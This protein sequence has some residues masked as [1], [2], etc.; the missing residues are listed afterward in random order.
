[1]LNVTDK[2]ADNLQDKFSSLLFA[3]AVFS[4]GALLMVASMSHATVTLREHGSSDLMKL[5]LT[6]SISR[7]DLKS[8]DSALQELSRSGKRLHMNAIEI[9]S[10]GGGE[11]SSQ[12][13]GRRIRKAGLNTLVRADAVCHSAC[14][15]VL[16]AGLTRMPYG[17]IGIHRFATYEDRVSDQSL[18]KSHRR[19]SLASELYFEEMRV[20]PALLWA[21]QGYPVWSL[22]VLTRA[23]LRD[24]DIAGT[25]PVEEEKIYRRHARRAGKTVLDFLWAAK[26]NWAECSRRQEELEMT[27]YDCVGQKLVG[28]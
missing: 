24:F 13:L 11:A 25:D 22:R 16:I 9:N 21:A 19:I 3:L 4:V 23:E 17:Q 12:E 18:A 10:G 26:N 14:I 2:L 20:S 1:M 6:G 5:S 28:H 7:E 27:A 8:F 15:N